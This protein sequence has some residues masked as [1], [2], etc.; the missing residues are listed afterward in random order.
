MDVEMFT[1]EAVDAFGAEE[2]PTPMAVDGKIV[3]PD[4]L[5]TFKPLADGGL[6]K[7]KC[8][9]SIMNIDGK[10]PRKRVTKGKAPAPVRRLL[11]STIAGLTEWGSTTAVSRAVPCTREEVPE[12]VV[13]LPDADAMIGPVVELAWPHMPTGVQKTLIALSDKEDLIAAV[14]MWIEY[15]NQI[16]AWSQAEHTRRMESSNDAVLEVPSATAGSGQYPLYNIDAFAPAEP[17]L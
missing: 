10:Q 14:F 17:A 7:H 1:A 13:S 2:A 15:I 3:C 5:K 9:E 8:V 12:P 6:R 11:V 4:C 16:K